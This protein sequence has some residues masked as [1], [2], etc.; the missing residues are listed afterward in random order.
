MATYNQSIDA[1]H[2]LDK[3]L[4]GTD[5][6]RYLYEFDEE[7]LHAFARQNHSIHQEILHTYIDAFCCLQNVLSALMVRKIDLL[8][9]R[10]FL[11]PVMRETRRNYGYLGE[12]IGIYHAAIQQSR[13]LLHRIF[14]EVMN[15]E[16]ICAEFAIQLVASQTVRE[17]QHYAVATPEATCVEEAD[18]DGQAGK[19]I[20]DSVKKFLKSFL[21]TLPIGRK[22]TKEERVDKVLHALNEMLGVLFRGGVG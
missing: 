10:Q 3:L 4:S 12:Y 1:I 2:H 6:E 15:D 9:E 14:E 20:T 5:Y 21:N 13:Q 7:N 16:L 8:Q 17:M 19:E 11:N 18:Q 22:K